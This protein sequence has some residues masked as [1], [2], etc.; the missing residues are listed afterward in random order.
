V[1]PVILDVGT[2]CKCLFKASGKNY[3]VLLVK[4]LIDFFSV[5]LRPNAVH[6]LLVLEVSISHTTTHY[7]R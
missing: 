6:G 7:S 4:Y 1:A 5:A 2:T 3:F